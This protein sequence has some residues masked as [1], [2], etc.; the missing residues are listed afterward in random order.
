MDQSNVDKLTKECTTYKP[1]CKR[2][3]TTQIMPRELHAPLFHNFAP[4]SCYVHWSI[5]LNHFCHI[6]KWDLKGPYRWCLVMFPKPLQ[7]RWGPCLGDVKPTKPQPWGDQ[8]ITEG[9]GNSVLYH[10]SR[11][12]RIWA[13]P[14]FV[15]MWLDLCSPGLA[16][17]LCVLPSHATC[18][19][20]RSVAET[21]V[22]ET[23][24][25][26]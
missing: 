25:I 5:Y 7:V 1:G 16:F 17:A 6:V 23:L 3:E 14:G 2:R 10:C 12:I 8:D 13:S 9:N 21:N 22:V 26:I 19:I 15:F 18:Q 24:D 20:G 4:N 11:R